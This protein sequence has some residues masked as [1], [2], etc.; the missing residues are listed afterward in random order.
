MSTMLESN[1]DEARHACAR[2]LAAAH[3]RNFPE[4]GEIYLAPGEDGVVR[5]LEVV[6]DLDF[7]GSIYPVGFPP[8][9]EEGIDLPSSVILVHPTEW[10]WLREGSLSLPAGWGTLAALEPIA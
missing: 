10:K 8:D 1:L 2:R 4:T 5:L 9:P 6:R 7:T 3:R